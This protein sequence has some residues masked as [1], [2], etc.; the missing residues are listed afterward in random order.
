MAAVSR[1]FELFLTNG[2]DAVIPHQ[3]RNTGS[4]GL[5]AFI[6]QLISDP[7][8]AISPF[9]FFVNL[10][11]PFKENHIFFYPL[12]ERPLKPGIV[13]APTDFESSAHFLYRKLMLIIF[14][15]PVF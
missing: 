15:K 10:I 12:A 11:D 9:G 7:G 6:V 14:D 5:V 2:T 13:T 8:A 3:T 1:Y 4:A